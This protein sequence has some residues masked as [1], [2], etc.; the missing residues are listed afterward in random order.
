MIAFLNV[1]W[2]S[3]LPLNIVSS[4]LYQIAFRFSLS[5]YRVSTTFNSYGTS[6]S[7]FLLISSLFARCS[8][9]ASQAL[10]PGRDEGMVHDSE[11]FL[12]TLQSVHTYTIHARC[13]YRRFLLLRL[14]PQSQRISDLVEDV[15]A[16]VYSSN[17]FVRMIRFNAQR[18]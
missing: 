7:L 5:N 4:F 13:Q 3:C 1:V 12:S 8:D 16:V 17:P 14:L 11:R 2:D 10:F 6:S 15:D 9:I 18:R